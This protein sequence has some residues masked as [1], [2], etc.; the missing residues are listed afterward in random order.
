M[1][2]AAE[3]LGRPSGRRYRLAPAP[4]DS[5]GGGAVSR[6]QGD[7][8]VV[9]KVFPT[10][11]RLDEPLGR[12]LSAV[13]SMQLASPYLACVGELLVE[14]TD[15]DTL[16]G[17]TM[18]R[19]V[20]FTLYSV[21]NPDERKLLG[22]ALSPLD[23]LRLAREVARAFAAIHALHVRLADAHHRNVMVRFDRRGRVGTTV[24]LEP[25]TWLFE[26]RTNG[27]M[28]R[29]TSLARADFLPAEFQAADLSVTPLTFESDRFAL[30]LL[31]S[32][33]LFDCTPFTFAGSA[34]PVEKRIAA[35]HEWVTPNLPQGATAPDRLPTDPAGVPAGVLD[36]L[37]RGVSRTPSA[38]PSAGEWATALADWHQQTLDRSAAGRFLAALTALRQARTLA[39]LRRRAVDATVATLRRFAPALAAKPGGWWVT[40]GV[41]VGVVAAALAGLAVWSWVP[42]ARVPPPA[43][44]AVAS[45][46]A[47]LPTP[48]T[49][50]ARPPWQAVLLDPN[51]PDPE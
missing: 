41:K 49:P 20:G 50:P 31:V 22:I 3:F 26:W 29:F 33:A 28:E 48:P 25:D 46:A 47:P 43:A 36:L 15:P 10:P 39:D 17:F 6:V 23:R 4:F 24:L 13:R 44:D 34:Q 8:T 1:A 40:L 16:V 7:D 19:V 27:R 11:C 12:R 51:D 42:N 45:P 32:L 35:G 14:P 38:R 30:A 37:R 9:A 5:G 21:T 18:N 2:P